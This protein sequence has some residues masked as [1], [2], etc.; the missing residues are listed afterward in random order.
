VLCPRK[1]M[2]QDGAWPLHGTVNAYYCMLPVLHT[3]LWKRHEFEYVSNNAGTERLPIVTHY[4]LCDFILPA[5]PRSLRESR[6]A[7]AEQRCTHA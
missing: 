5:L 2:E 1:L 3:R 4:A 6:S 7:C